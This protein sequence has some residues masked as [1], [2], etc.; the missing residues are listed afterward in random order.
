MDAA[1]PA[2]P[3]SPTALRPARALSVVLVLAS[4]AY[5]VWHTVRWTGP[6]VRTVSS[7]PATR[8]MAC[9]VS[10]TT[11]TWIYVPLLCLVLCWSFASGAATEAKQ[12]RRRSWLYLSAGVSAMLL[13]WWVTIR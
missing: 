3:D 5:A 12:G 8:G 4:L 13:A 6:L 9:L 7:C 2:A 11:Y 10:D 1:Q